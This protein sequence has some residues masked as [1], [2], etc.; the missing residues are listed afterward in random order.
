MVKSKIINRAKKT[1]STEVREIQSLSKIFNDNF[2]KAVIL[3][4]KV[5]GRVIVTGIGKS[6]HIGNK[7]SAT[8]TSTGTPSYFIHATEASHGDL[9]GIRKNDCIF[10]ISNSGETSELN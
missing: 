6:A 1:L 8:L 7:I 3:L 4:S 9:G 10:A 5:K 2:Y